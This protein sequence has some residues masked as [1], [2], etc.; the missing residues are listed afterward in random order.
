MQQQKALRLPVEHRSYV[1]EDPDQI[2]IGELSI[3]IGVSS[4]S[5]KK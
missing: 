3:S 5:V 4:F 2:T 1:S